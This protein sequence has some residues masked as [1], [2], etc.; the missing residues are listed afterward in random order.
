MMAKGTTALLITNCS[1]Y[2]V[3]EA[4]ASNT[5]F[6]CLPYKDDQFYISEAL[7][8]PPKYKIK[9]YNSEGSKSNKDECVIDIDNFEQL[10]PYLTLNDIANGS[11]T[12]GY[13]ANLLLTLLKNDSIYKTN[14]EKAYEYLHC[15]WDMSHKTPQQLFKQKVLE[16]LS[17]N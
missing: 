15:I 4:I 10:A 5:P 2:Q 8:I 16:V 6:L 11:I 14:V 3:I 7:Q 13:I 9:K 17:K 1:S 12:S